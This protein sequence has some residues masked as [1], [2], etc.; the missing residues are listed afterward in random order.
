MHEQTLTLFGLSHE[1]NTGGQ[2]VTNATT[3]PHYFKDNG[4]VSIGM[5]KT[6]HPGAPNGNDI[7]YSWSLPADG[8]SWHSFKA[9]N[10]LTDGQVEDNAAATLQEIKYNRSKGDDR[11]S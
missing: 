6:F 9:D 7:K 5:V 1:M 2:L 4:Y 8:V 10:M 11:I 3:I